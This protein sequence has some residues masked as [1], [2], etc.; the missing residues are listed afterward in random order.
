MHARLNL[1]PASPGVVSRQIVYTI[2]AGDPVTIDLAAADRE[3]PWID[4]AEGEV[5]AGTLIDTDGE[6]ADSPAR[7]FSFTCC[8]TYGITADTSPPPMPA[9]LGIAIIP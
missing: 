6:D 5:L 1:P 3:T 9:V 4:V 2:D 7:S 8:D